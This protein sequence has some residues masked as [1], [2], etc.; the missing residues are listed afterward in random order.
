MSFNDK[1]LNVCF[2]VG[3]VLLMIMLVIIIL[4]TIVF[5]GLSVKTTVEMSKIKNT[6]YQYLQDTEKLEKIIATEGNS[7]TWD[8]SNIAEKE[9]LEKQ[10]KEKIKQ[11]LQNNGMGNYSV[12]KVLGYLMQ[13]A[14]EDRDDYVKNMEEH[15][16]IY[17]KFY[18]DMVA[19][20][21][22]YYSETEIKKVIV[23][24]DDIPQRYYEQRY[25]KQV[26]EKAEKYQKANTE[27]NF[28]LLT[29]LSCIYTFILML[30]IP[31]LIRIEENTR[32]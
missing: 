6:P 14:P 1:F 19:K 23:N 22:P 5:I 15:H 32:K 8:E 28:Q 26:E 20:R 9:N 29:V 27:R 4:V 30:I 12:D 25:K 13:V 3:K 2:K 18:A 31:L 16:R 7:D 17:I 11:A 10:Y 21:L 24:N